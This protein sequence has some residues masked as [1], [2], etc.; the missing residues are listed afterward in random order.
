MRGS[1][2]FFFGYFLDRDRLLK[3]SP[4]KGRVRGSFFASTTAKCQRFGSKYQQP[5][6]QPGKWGYMLNVQIAMGENRFPQ[7]KKFDGCQL[8]VSADVAA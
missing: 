6:S 5:L 2:T 7:V 3:P 4:A 1:E 8:H